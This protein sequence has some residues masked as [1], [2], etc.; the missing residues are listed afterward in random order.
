MWCI[1]L[2]N[3]EQTAD[4]SHRVLPEWPDWLPLVTALRLP[5]QTL[6]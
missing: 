3:V 6:R 4:T 1:I 5:L 2:E